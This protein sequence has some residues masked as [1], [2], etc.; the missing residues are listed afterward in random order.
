[1]LENNLHFEKVNWWKIERY[2]C[3]LVKRDRKLWCT[4]IEDI[5]EFYTELE[6][7]KNNISELH[8]NIPNKK[9][10]I[11]INNMLSNSD[12]LL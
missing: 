1:L 11:Y 12:C 10:I 9:N 4:I 7:Y 2:E 3:T 6:Y 8:D 5:V